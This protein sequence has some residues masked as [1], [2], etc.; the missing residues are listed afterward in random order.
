MLM[1]NDIDAVAA[2]VQRPKTFHAKAF[3]IQDI[4]RACLHDGLIGSWD[5]GLGKTIFAFLWPLLKCGHE[6][7]LLD[8]PL[9]LFGLTHR[10]ELRPRKPVLIIAPGDLHAQFATEA[11]KHFRLRLIPIDSQAA[12]EN[13]TREAHGVRTR[14][15]ERGRPV[16]APAFY[17]TSYQ[18]LASNG[19][20]KIPR[21]SESDHPRGL[22]EEWCLPIGVNRPAI[23]MQPDGQ[24]PDHEDDFDRLLP[25]VTT[26]VCT[27]HAWRGRV[28]HVEFG[29]LGLDPESSL[30]DLDKAEARARIEI[31]RQR[32]PET[33]AKMSDDL[34]SALRVLTQVLGRNRGAGFH[35][36]TTS[37]QNWII[38]Q[39]LGH[40]YQEFTEC[41]DGEND[42][43]SVA[44]V[45]NDGVVT[46]VVQLPDGELIASKAPHG[47]RWDIWKRLDGGGNSSNPENKTLLTCPADEALAVAWLREHAKEHKAITKRIR[48]L[49]SPS[50]ADLCYDAFTCVVVDEGVKMKGEDTMIGKGV[51]LM[52]PEFRLCLTATP[53]KNRL[54][55]IFRL[56]WWATGGLEH[57]HARWPY[58]DDS[59]ERER[60]AATFLVSERN[61]T[62]EKEKGK[63][64]TKLTAEVCNVHG[65]W[66]L[67]GP[68][69]LRRRKQDCGEEIVP[70]I[71]KVVRV[72]MGTEQARVYQYHLQATYKD[73]NGMK[74]VGPQLQ[75]LRTISADPTSD[76]LQMKNAVTTTCP[77]C[78]GAG[79]KKAACKTCAGKGDVPLPHRSAHPF[80]PKHAAVLEI[81]AEVL[82]RKE[83][84][85]I[86]SAFNDPNDLLSRWLH[87]AGVKHEILDGRLTPTKR[88]QRC[89][90]FKEGRFNT[91]SVPVTLCG[92]ESMAEGHSFHRANN[93]IL[94]AYSWAY[95][96][97]K[98]FLDR[99]HRMN[100]EF[101]VNVYVI[102]C[103]GS[104]DRRLE[105]LIQEKTDSVELVLDGRLI[106]EASEEVNLAQLLR[107]AANTF[108]SETKT[109]DEALLAH[110]WHDLR[111]RIQVAAL[112]WTDGLPVAATPQVGHV[113]PCAP[114]TGQKAV[115]NF[116][117]MP[118][119]IL[120][121]DSTETADNSK[122]NN[123]NNP[124][125]KKPRFNTKNLK[126]REPATQLQMPAAAEAPA[127]AGDWRARC[128]QRA[129]ILANLAKPDVQG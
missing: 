2:P 124:P 54:P 90:T 112:R 34:E 120:P 97:F 77:T 8:A 35:D 129:A 80:I 128:R 27:F 104:I 126:L 44:R 4:A 41:V 21:P 16:I 100:S 119:S 53:I 61:L 69:I 79:G 12:F 1:P 122:N 51:R 116:S 3:Q 15:D 75:A 23:T 38:R 14:R 99:V 106:G 66:K 85:M 98:Q 40:K 96:K 74:A 92:V 58:A 118:F 101:P 105:S 62:R 25:A 72:E 81:I 71:R 107:E 10:S 19:K 70:R 17:I 68:V 95:D 33:R 86:G 91:A 59:A 32:D 125:M 60:F 63:R 65:L 57:A 114:R 117:A 36:L 121:D 78:K 89:A 48:C 83:Q 55:D 7:V 5:T 113:T 45:V 110:R 22:L 94:Y 64:F 39:Y 102:L 11:W 30:T 108:N 127:P 31:A 103:E 43:V 26:D 9:E 47:Q 84:V 56:A 24:W 115:L 73:K 42:V 67:F 52:A 109:I 46:H 50:L 28:W 93:V 13:L 20:S 49:Y 37:Q 18:Q 88:G 29:V 6:K 82:E 76:G 111:T 87:E 123:S